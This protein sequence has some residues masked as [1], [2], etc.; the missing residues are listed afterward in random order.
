M[1]EAAAAPRG[2]ENEAGPSTN[3]PEAMLDL[4]PTGFVDDLYNVVRRRE[5]I[6]ERWVEHPARP[7]HPAA[8]ARPD[9]R[10]CSTTARRA[11]TR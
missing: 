6:S 1:D 11:L 4:N 2:A 9:L 8:P 7:A 3:T 10:R 5:G